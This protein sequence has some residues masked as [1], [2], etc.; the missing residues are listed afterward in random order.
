VVKGPAA[1]ATDAP[2][3]SGLL[4]KSVMMI[5]VFSFFPRNGAAVAWNWR[6]KTEVLGE[7]PVPVSLYLP[8]IPHG[9]NRDRTRASAV[10]GRRLTAWAMARLIFFCGFD[11][12]WPSVV[13]TESDFWGHFPKPKKKCFLWG[14]KYGNVI[15]AH[16]KIEHSLRQF[17]RNWEN[18]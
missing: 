9:L 8:Q 10:R 11:S 17:S 14:R 4:C 15:Y 18:A 1:D 3:P 7:K 5:S 13:K 2:Q 16:K 12:I 6:E